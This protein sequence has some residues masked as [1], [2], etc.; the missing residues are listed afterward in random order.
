M[1]DPLL[2][3]S[4]NLDSHNL[5]Y[6]H[7]HEIVGSFIFYQIIFYP[8]LAPWICRFLFGK[9]YT[10]LKDTKVRINYDIHMVSMMQC[11]ISLALISPILFTP[12]DPHLATYHNSYLSMISAVTIGYFLWDLYIC[13]KHLDLFGFGFLI[14]AILSL[15]VF[16]VSLRPMCQ[17]W[18]GKFLIF[19]ISTPFVNI[20]WY[21]SQLSRGSNISVVPM[22][23]N[24]L[25]GILLIITFFTV[26]IVWGLIAITLLIQQ[27][28]KI[29]DL[30][31]KYISV[32]IISIN[33]VLNCLN[34]IWFQKMIKIAQKMA[35]K[36]KV[37][38]VN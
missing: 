27:M 4:W 26:R 12:L 35:N 7:G 18:I 36:S 21:I 2:R 24:M 6:K 29:R 17:T 16:T 15:A 25:N 20:N 23:F 8:Y 5:Y 3:Y 37:D 38:K 32:L 10:N 28:W 14:H 33:I 1:E 34:L 9:Y 11:L 22:W 19:E 31:P 30:L 13:L